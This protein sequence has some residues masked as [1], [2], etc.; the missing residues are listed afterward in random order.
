MTFGLFVRWAHLAASVL[1]V[2]AFAMTLL[3]GAPRWPT[4]RAWQASVLA[5][6]RALLLAAIVF[7]LASLAW[8]T[9]VLEGR[10][11]AALDPAALMRVLL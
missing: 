8:Q 9:A 5:W 1:V 6:A 10:G 4:A 2:G 11:G 7:G 3:A